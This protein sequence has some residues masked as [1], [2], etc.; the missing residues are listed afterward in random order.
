MTAIAIDLF[1]GCFVYNVVDY[2]MLEEVRFSDL[3]DHL[4]VL[5]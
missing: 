3:A 4:S 1:V 5:T 2:E